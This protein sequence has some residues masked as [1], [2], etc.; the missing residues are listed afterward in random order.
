MTRRKAE[1]ENTMNLRTIA[2]NMTELSINSVGTVLFSYNTPVA[3]RTPDGIFKTEKFW[4][5][6][7]SKHINKWGAKDAETRPQEYFDNLTK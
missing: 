4:S 1:S 3:A 5:T 7:T 2:P 6:T